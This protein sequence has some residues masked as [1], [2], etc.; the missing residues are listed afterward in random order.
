MESAARVKLLGKGSDNETQFLEIL[1]QQGWQ[2]SRRFLFDESGA[3]CC[4][5]HSVSDGVG[6]VVLD[7]LSTDELRRLEASMCG[8]RVP[9]IAVVDESALAVSDIRHLILDLCFGF[10]TYPV[11]H[12]SLQSLLRNAARLAHV[13]HLEDDARGAD[14]PQD[15][16]SEY[17]MVGTTP[18]MW[19]LFKTIRKVAAVDASV[20]IHGESGTGKELTAQAI[21]ERSHRLSGPF[22]AINCGALPDNLIQSELFGHE[23]GSFTGAAQRKIGRIEAADG[24]TLF[25]DEIGDLPLDLQVNLLRFLETRRIQR[26]GSLNE[27]DVDVRVV[28]ATHVDL[29]KAV[30]EGRF[31]ED[32]YHRLNVLQVVVPALREHPEDIEI[33]ARFFFKRFAGEKPATLRGFSRESMAT[34]RQYPWPGNV[35]ELINRIRRAMVMCE[36]RLIQPDDLG[37]ER[38]KI[39][40]HIRTLDQSRDRAECDAILSALVRNKYCINAAAEELD[41]SRVTLYRLLNKHGIPRPSGGA[42]EDDPAS[43]PAQL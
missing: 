12:E 30:D 22:Q 38:R 29:A 42:T 14:A 25:L 36:G 39:H 13:Q 37:I 32:L 19:D 6:V 34:M 10:V 33:M 4:H 35:R 41:I 27:I 16:V 7:A 26:I 43:H 21:H 1:Q 8:I 31:R 40:R 20:C 15:D 3:C 24:G 5:Q 17:E 23:K 11:D 2:V 28:A 9:W 18:V